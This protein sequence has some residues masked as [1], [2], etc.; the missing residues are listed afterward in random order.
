MQLRSDLNGAAPLKPVGKVE[1]PARPDG[2]AEPRNAALQRSLSGLVGKSMLA[3]V[4]A[5]MSDGNFV[6]KVDGNAMRMIL[7]PGTKV[8]A[9]VPL[10]L[11]GLEPRPTFQVGENG[12]PVTASLYT[13]NA[14]AKGGAQPGALGGAQQAAALQAALLKNAA[15]AAVT[16]GEAGGPAPVLSETGRLLSSVLSAA[17]NAPGAALALEGSQPLLG[18]AAP[19]PAQLAVKLQQT[20]SQSGLFYES[21]LAEWAE[22]TRSMTELMH[23]PQAARA[24][25]PPTDPNTAQFINL[26]LT[27]Q[28]QS[29]V[30]WQ[31]QLTAGHELEWHIEKD[32]R[33]QRGGDEDDAP[34]WRS[35]MMFRLP[36]LGEIAATVVMA[37]DKFQIEIQTGSD[38]VGSALRAHAGQLSSAMEAAGTPLSALSIGVKPAPE[39]GHG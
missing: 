24:P 36:L 38:A 13:P 12:K 22:G 27:S 14:N 32:E 39:D 4:L 19:E 7:P 20:I 28:E 18:K 35:G 6:V 10:T 5:R 9:D 21:H 2:V 16:Q 17:Q 31:G 25:V 30:V 15:A 8:G 26:Q 11:L 23:E 1:V 33:G 29:R 3:Q 37:G 34:V